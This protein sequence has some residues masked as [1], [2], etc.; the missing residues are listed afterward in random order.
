MG[1][2]QAINNAR[3]VLASA[4]ASGSGTLALQPG[5]GARFGTPSPGAPVRVTAVASPGRNELVYGIY[6]ATGRSG[7][8]LTVA[9]TEGF[10]DVAI[11]AGATVEARVTAGT[12]AEL[13]AAILTLGAPPD[14]VN[15]DTATIHAGRPVA[16]HSSGVGVVLATAADNLRAAAGLAV[17]DAA[18][19]AAC[20][21]QPG[22]VLALA[23][24][25][26][27]TGAPTL[28]A[29]ATYYLAATPGLL[30]TTPPAVAGQVVQTI[31]LA[32]SPTQLEIRI[33]PPILL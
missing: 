15:Q 4:H 29:R 1:F 20:I 9:P 30:T 27:A 11:P 2:A 12:I 24:W 33:D 10:A 18:P 23:D 21:V 28:A 25:T 32:L 22:G 17:A 6:L 7:D 31:G 26:L 8:T 16:V 5:Q 13:Q 3:G 19:G 14:E